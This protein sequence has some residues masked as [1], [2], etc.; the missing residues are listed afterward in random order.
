MAKGTRRSKQ[1][2]PLKLYKFR[3]LGDCEAFCR[4]QRIIEMGAFWC[5]RFWDLNDPMEGVFTVDSDKAG[6]IERIFNQK[7]D[8]VICS[9][10]GPK[11]F[12]NPAMWGYYANGF[13]GVAIEV[14]VHQDCVKK[15]RYE[16]NVSQVAPM[17][18]IDAILTT[19]LN[20]WKHEDE[21]RFLGEGN[22]GERRI[23]RVTALFF[24][25]PYASTANSNSVFRQAPDL[26]CYR[27]RRDD[28]KVIARKVP[29]HDVQ[30][31]GGVVRAVP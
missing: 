5:S 31:R 23:G 6:L 26:E 7:S 17:G 1:H 21:Y 12:K 9:F 19:K 30:V 29:C 16:K 14:E 15:V 4:V 27:R 10:S 11:A 20:Q 8:R 22:T 25:N 24:G 28:L 18:E 3:A 2:Q 13:R